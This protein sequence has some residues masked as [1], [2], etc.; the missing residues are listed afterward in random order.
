MR[1]SCLRSAQDVAAAAAAVMQGVLVVDQSRGDPSHIEVALSLA[2]R[3]VR[4]A[5]SAAD[6]AAAVIAQ[7]QGISYKLYQCL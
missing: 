2:G 3:A 6:T 1:I 7:A 5:Y 4:S